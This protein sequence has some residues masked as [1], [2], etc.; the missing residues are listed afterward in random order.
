MTRIALV[1]F[2]AGGGHRAAATALQQ[3]VQQQHLPW[4]AELVNLQEL[5]DPEEADVARGA[6]VDRADA[7]GVKAVVTIADD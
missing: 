5:L 4:N 3:I 2:D 7:V 6:D 1:Y